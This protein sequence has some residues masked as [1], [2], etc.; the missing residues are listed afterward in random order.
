MNSNLNAW[1][2]P[3][4]GRQ[5]TI[6]PC[7]I[8][9]LN[10]CNREHSTKTFLNVLTVQK[11]DTALPLWLLIEE[12]FPLADSI[13]SSLLLYLICFLTLC[14]P[15][16][17]HASNWVSQCDASVQ[18]SHRWFRV[19]ISCPLLCFYRVFYFWICGP[20]Q[21]QLHLLRWCKYNLKTYDWSD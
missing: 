1:A 20:S 17:P 3:F 11:V 2:H 10:K 15:V 4:R 12:I 6:W 9:Q 13:R 5:R 8:C 7:S 16:H 18:V 19:C 21:W 14:D